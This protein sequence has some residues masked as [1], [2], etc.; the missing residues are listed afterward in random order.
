MGFYIPVDIVIPQVLV[1]G[2]SS[3][4]VPVVNGVPKGLSLVQYYS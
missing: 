1:E 4:K 2:Q 3:E